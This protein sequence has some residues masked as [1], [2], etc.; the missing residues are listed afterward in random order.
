MFSRR[1][2]VE[3]PKGLSTIDELFNR[4]DAK[5]VDASNQREQRTRDLHDPH[6]PEM[7]A[8]AALARGS[9]RSTR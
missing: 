1:T 3:V 5:V 6:Y 8:I 2:K 4:F 7:A 9:L